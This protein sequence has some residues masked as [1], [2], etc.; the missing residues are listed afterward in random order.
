[1]T[2]LSESGKLNHPPLSVTLA[3]TEE[4][5]GSIR[6]GEKYITVA[7]AYVITDTESAQLAANELTNINK[8]IDKITA[9]RKGFIQPAQQIMENAKALFNP[10]IQGYEASA[11]L[12]KER[13]AGWQESERKRIALENAQREEEARRVRQEAERKA[14][15]EEA[16]AKQKAEEERRKAEAAEKQRQEAEAAGDTRAAAAAAAQVAGANERAQQALENGQAKASEAHLKAATAVAAAPVAA[17]VKIAGVSSR[18]RFVAELKPGITEDAAKALIVKA[19]AEGRTD[20]L[21]ILE[22]SDKALSQLARAQ[23]QHM[24]VPGYVSVDRPI[25]AG[26]RK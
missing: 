4:I 3:L 10:A 9:L 19:A 7:E 14:A 23:K 16:R 15:E 26:S 24:D 21:A 11:A 6:Q 8:A 13:L 22:I 2:D 17:P 18:E 1:M 5:S 25:M 20:L 12:L